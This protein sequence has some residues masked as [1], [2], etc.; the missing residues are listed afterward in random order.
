MQKVRYKVTS[1]FAV[2]RQRDKAPR[3]LPVGF[4]FSAL[5][6]LNNPVIL[7]IGSERFESDKSGFA[8][9]T[10]RTSVD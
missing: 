4:C 1:E 5:K 9:H 10:I 2:L 7:E 8:A 3:H 6:P